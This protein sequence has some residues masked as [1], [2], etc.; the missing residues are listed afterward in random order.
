MQKKYTNLSFFV[1]NC[2]THN[3]REK[4]KVKCYLYVCINKKDYGVV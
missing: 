2:G 4:A 3:K 1:R